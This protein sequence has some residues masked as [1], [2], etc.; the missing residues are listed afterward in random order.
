MAPIKFED[1]LK[2]KLE[3][4]SLE[5]S[6][7][8]W[9]TLQSRLDAHEKQHKTTRFWWIGIAASVIGIVFIITQ[10]NKNA[11]S[12]STA[13]VIVTTDDKPSVTTDVTE[14]NVQDAVVNQ[15]IKNQDLELVMTSESN[16]ASV[17]ESNTE[18]VY[19]ATISD[20]Q[21]KIIEEQPLENTVASIDKP[22][23]IKEVEKETPI[24]VLSAEDLKVIEVVAEIKAMQ[25]SETSVSNREIDSL[26]KQAQR[27]ILRQKIFDET[28]QTVSAD[29]LLQDVEVE[30]EQ[31]FRAK[32]F[33]ALKDNFSSV[34]TAVAER[35]N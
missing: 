35:N 4:R 13:P 14:E 19:Q 7:E 27:D 23:V 28:T 10:F 29:A 34:K 24:K 1:Q 12:Q 9:N 6:S 15:E 20:K 11:T 26:L 21:P 25:Q 33:D 18:N 16:A 17:S 32:V 3:R 31:S 8:A 30:L 5:P 22:D 2:D